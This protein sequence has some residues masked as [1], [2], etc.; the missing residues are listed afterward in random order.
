MQVMWGRN[1]E[2]KKET[3]KHRTIL[4]DNFG[5]FFMPQLYSFLPIYYCMKYSRH[6]GVFLDL[7]STTHLKCL[8]C[9]L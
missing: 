6:A 5:D 3:C 2:T 7:L 4:M 1:S 8:E 9:K